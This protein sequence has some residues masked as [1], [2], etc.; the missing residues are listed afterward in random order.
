M[1]ADYILKSNNVFDSVRDK[2]F[3][4]IVAVSGNR[5]SG[6]FDK[7]CL[8]EHRGENTKVI[9]CG[10]RLVMPGFIDSHTY[11]YGNG[12]SGRELLR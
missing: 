3:A 8:E 1:Y 2:P 7:D 5:I 4:G 9:D 12:F 11:R 6:V 10:N